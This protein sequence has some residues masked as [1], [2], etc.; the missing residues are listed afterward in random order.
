MHAT[1]MREISQQSVG[2]RPGFQANGRLA[3]RASY[4]RHNARTAGVTLIGREYSGEGRN[5]PRHRGCARRM[6]T[7]RAIVSRSVRDVPSAPAGE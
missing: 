4:R 2:T 5:S 1:L 6:S 3:G 7:L